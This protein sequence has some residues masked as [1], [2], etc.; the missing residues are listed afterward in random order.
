MVA[1]GCG[2]QQKRKADR[3]IHVMRRERS[4]VLILSILPFSHLFCTFMRKFL[5]AISRYDLVSDETVI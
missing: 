2:L 3:S 5:S 4:R 1:D